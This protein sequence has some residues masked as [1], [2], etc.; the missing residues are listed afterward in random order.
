[1]LA[2]LGDALSAFEAGQA[3]DDIAMLA[4]QRLGAAAYAV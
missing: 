4:V 3:Q 1:M 2:E